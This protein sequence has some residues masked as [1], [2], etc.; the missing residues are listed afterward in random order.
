MKNELKN[1]MRIKEFKQIEIVRGRE[2]FLLINADFYESG[3]GK[4]IEARKK[5]FSQSLQIESFS[6][7]N[8]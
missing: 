3:I 4:R 5:N 6:I 8:V 2:N 7:F 1:S